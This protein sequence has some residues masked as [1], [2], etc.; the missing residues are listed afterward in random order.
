[1]K[2]IAS[3]YSLYWRFP[4]VN[5]EF[6]SKLEWFKTPHLFLFF[7]FKVHN[8][9]ESVTTTTTTQSSRPTLKSSR[10]KGTTFDYTFSHHLFHIPSSRYRRYQT[11]PCCLAATVS[12]V[13]RSWVWFSA[14]HSI[15]SRLWTDWVRRRETNSIRMEWNKLRLREQ[16][17]NKQMLMRRNWLTGNICN[18][19]GWYSHSSS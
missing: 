17:G 1:M 16:L 5:F 14:R 12:Y 7:T 9:R 11:N 13:T 3:I 8:L 6:S 2:W 19:Y 10:E 18:W 15:R 4:V